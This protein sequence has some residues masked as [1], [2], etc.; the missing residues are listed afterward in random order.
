MENITVKELLDI[1]QKHLDKL[2]G[3]NAVKEGGVSSLVQAAINEI[4]EISLEHYNIDVYS[5]QLR[6]YCA[7]LN[8]DIAFANCMPEYRPDKRKYMGKGDVLD[9]VTVSLD[10]RKNIPL[11]LE[12]VNLAQFLDYTVAKERFD[13]LNN[14]QEEMMETYRSNCKNM[15]NL[16]NIM[17]TCAYDTKTA[18]ESESAYETLNDLRKRV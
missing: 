12:V 18:A 5:C 11:D 1:V 3:K 17:K 13:R 16:Q 4:D 10:K 2:K 15:E 7:G 8:R 9:S 6:A 14:E